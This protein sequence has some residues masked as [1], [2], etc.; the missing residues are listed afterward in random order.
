MITVDIPVLSP[1][2]GDGQ[3]HCVLAFERE[4]HRFESLHH[5]RP[6]PNGGPLLAAAPTPEK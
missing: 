6:T 4:S 1:F 5:R 3:A 2:T